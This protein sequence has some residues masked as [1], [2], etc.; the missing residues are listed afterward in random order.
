[1]TVG[2]QTFTKPEEAGAALQNRMADY[3]NLWRQSKKK[4]AMPVGEYGG[5]DIYIEPWSEFG[6]FGREPRFWI[7]TPDGSAAWPV[8]NSDSKSGQV[9]RLTN[10]PSRLPATI[11]NLEGL[12]AQQLKTADDLR[13]EVAKPF[14]HAERLAE[15]QRQADEIDKKLKTVETAV[16]GTTEEVVSPATPPQLDDPQQDSAEDADTGRNVALERALAEREAQ[17]TSGMAQHAAMFGGRAM[18]KAEI[19]PGRYLAVPRPVRSYL[20][21]RKADP[22][23]RGKPDENDP[24]LNPPLPPLSRYDQTVARHDMA[25]AT[26]QQA[27]SGHARLTHNERRDGPLLEESHARYFHIPDDAVTVPLH[28]L[29]ATRDA[30]VA[31]APHAKAL[32]AAAKGKKEK[33]APVLASDMGD[34]S[35][36][37]HGTHGHRILATAH[38]NG[39]RSLPVVPIDMGDLDRSG[40]PKMGTYAHRVLTASDPGSTPYFDAEVMN[41]PPLS[42]QEGSGVDE[43]Y[44]GARVGHDQMG[45]LLGGIARR[46]GLKHHGAGET[47]DLKGA[48]GYLQGKD[49]PGLADT[50]ADAE[51]AGGDW[52]ALKGL[53]RHTIAVERPA[54]ARRV[55]EHL[56]AAGIE[57]AER[58][59]ETFSDPGPLGQRSAVLHVRAPNG[60]VARVGI[61]LKAMLRARQQAE[62][63]HRAM[64]TLDA[65]AHA[66][67]RDLEPDERRR[68]RTAAKK[69]RALYDAA[70]RTANG[71][72]MAKA[73]GTERMTVPFTPKIHLKPDDVEQ[74]D[75]AYG[76]PRWNYKGRPGMLM[77]GQPI[78]P[79]ERHTLPPRL[80]HV[81]TNLPAVHRTGHLRAAADTFS[82]GLGGN[83]GGPHV[84]FTTN[85][86]DA[87]LIKRELERSVNLTSGR[88]PIEKIRD[89]ATEDEHR[90]HLPAGS[91][92][93]AAEE[94]LRNH[95]EHLKD[96]ERNNWYGDK[97]AFLASIAKQAH[98]NYTIGRSRYAGFPEVKHPLLQDPIMFGDAEML[99]KIEPRHIGILGVP[100]E[101]IPKG[102]LVRSMKEGDRDFLHEVQ[103]HGDV[104]VAGSRYVVSDKPAPAL[105]KAVMGQ[106]GEWRGFIHPNGERISGEGRH[107]DIAAQHVKAHPDLGLKPGITSERDLMERGYVRAIGNP[108]EVTVDLWKKPSRRQMDAIE[109]L[110][111]ENDGADFKWDYGDPI[112]TPGPDLAYG[113]DHRSFQ[114]WRATAGMA[115]GGLTAE[116]EKEPA[117]GGEK[118]S[119]VAYAWHD[120]PAYAEGD[121]SDPAVRIFIYRRGKWEPGNQHRSQLLRDAHRVPTA[122]MQRLMAESEPR[123][124]PVRSSLDALS[125]G[126]S[127]GGKQ[128]LP[129]R[130]EARKN[131]S[132]SAPPR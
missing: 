51:A 14:M 31:V 32:D 128:K 41:L 23:G 16:G 29:V 20:L 65:I 117:F 76:T 126:G 7:A 127:G 118:G 22:P 95:A 77:E 92:R 80:Y 96:G 35:Y 94:A 69:A 131:T 49:V 66:Q 100:R 79:E 105:S 101:N 130:D 55:L 83:A 57:H 13:T 37:V 109:D 19:P 54:D 129:L 90:E 25:L 111:A 52:G 59:K 34:G 78:P 28:Q 112:K 47:P 102:A 113:N 45:Q 132:A 8:D 70:W 24:L 119:C 124:S 42:R 88:H 10:V 84:S 86:H 115:K 3:L 107:D 72:K 60:H 91:L 123:Q 30:K 125:R 5:F 103:V 73:L 46:L 17:N 2:K 53:S 74:Y 89:Y 27:R 44:A 21:M 58:P 64:E 39:W 15:L 87:V 82:G 6:K 43:V 33:S 50:W 36:R 81:T 108:K 11:S 26:R 1:M 18:G 38:A 63:H 12:R 106:A 104:P 97:P 110:R 67:G 114:R 48:G 71:G 120:L 4:D 61:E 68:Y 85:R 56:S 99:R 98:Q 75:T 122:E 93:I 9:T 116:I 62:P 121:L 40:N